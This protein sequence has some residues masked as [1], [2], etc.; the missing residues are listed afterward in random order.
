MV[1]KGQEQKEKKAVDQRKPSPIHPLIEINTK[2]VT[3][4]L[5]QNQDKRQTMP[6]G[7]IETFDQSQQQSMLESAGKLL[8]DTLLSQKHS[9]LI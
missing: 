3:R 9:N 2:G 8:K 4:H 6:E 1:E 5:G 7:K